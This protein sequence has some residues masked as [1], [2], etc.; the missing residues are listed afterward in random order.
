[1]PVIAFL[2]QQVEDP[3]ATRATPDP[4]FARLGMGLVDVVSKVFSHGRPCFAE[5]KGETLIEVAARDL[6]VNILKKSGTKRSRN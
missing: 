1:M 2:G 3:Y 4:E 5:G 6:G